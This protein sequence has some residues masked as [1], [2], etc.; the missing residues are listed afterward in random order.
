[1][2]IADP[3]TVEDIDDLM[4]AS[5][6]LGARV[7]LRHVRSGTD[8]AVHDPLRL[9]SA[10]RDAFDGFLGEVGTAEAWLD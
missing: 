6:A 7:L 2:V 1:M 5:A 8:G 9:A 10:L 4:E 3:T